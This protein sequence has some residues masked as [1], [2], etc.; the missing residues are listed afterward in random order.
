MTKTPAERR[1]SDREAHYRM[2]ER[3]RKF[4]AQFNESD[5]ETFCRTMARTLTDKQIAT[6]KGWMTK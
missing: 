1:Q 6:L 3:M 5:A 2:R 4:L